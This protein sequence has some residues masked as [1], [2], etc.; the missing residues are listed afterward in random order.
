M[1]KLRSEKLKRKEHRL[2]KINRKGKR[3]GKGREGKKTG[4][5]G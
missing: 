3:E 5:V 2:E 4:E 1:K